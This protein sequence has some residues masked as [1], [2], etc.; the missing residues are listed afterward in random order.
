MGNVRE[1]D[2][3]FMDRSGRRIGFR[4]ETDSEP[5][6]RGFIV[7]LLTATAEGGNVGYIAC[8]YMTAESFARF[9][10]TVFNWM[11]QIAGKLV[12]PPGMETLDLQQAPGSVLTEV[13]SR[14][15]AYRIASYEPTA[16]LQDYADFSRWLAEADSHGSMRR[17]A[18]E[19]RAF[20]KRIDYPFVTYVRTLPSARRGVAEDNSGLGIGT[21][22]YRVMAKELAA[23]G[24]VLRAST[25]QSPEASALWRKFEE[26]GLAYR[27][28]DRLGKGSRLCFRDLPDV[29]AETGVA[30]PSSASFSPSAPRAF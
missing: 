7:D 30:E 16:S 17:F 27:E 2:V 13:A 8:E 26:R 23:R 20:S 24:M 29:R 9:H 18:A 28:K 22:L 21:A 11:D 10:P 3:E 12:M 1:L 6:N 14:L 25:L 19:F 5:P 15:A 4:Y